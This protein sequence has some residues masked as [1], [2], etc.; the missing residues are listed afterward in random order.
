MKK[1][2]VLIIFFILCFSSAASAKFFHIF[3]ISQKQTYNIGGTNYD[4]WPINSGGQTYY[5]MKPGDPRP[6]APTVYNIVDVLASSG[7]N[8]MLY[9]VTRKA[10]TAL[11]A[12]EAD[13]YAGGSDV[14]T[15]AAWLTFA[16]MSFMDQGAHSPF[17]AGAAAKIAIAARWKDAADEWQSGNINDWQAA[18]FPQN[19]FHVT[20]K[21]EILGA[22]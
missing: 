7:A 13:E 8:D 9:F 10:A 21:I 12:S 14:S 2:A 20:P 22:R 6:E 1:I 18:G 16:V 3:F 17:P 15:A 19:G 4:A 11:L 5:F